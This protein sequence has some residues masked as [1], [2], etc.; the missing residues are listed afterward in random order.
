[1][2]ER[3]NINPGPW[4]AGHGPGLILGSVRWNALFLASLAGHFNSPP[5]LA[6]HCGYGMAEEWLPYTHLKSL[7]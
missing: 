6:L 2:L 4:C 1:M 7:F 3:I 5:L